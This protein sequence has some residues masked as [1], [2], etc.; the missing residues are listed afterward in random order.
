MAF[1]LFSISYKLARLSFELVFNQLLVT[2][3]APLDVHDGQKM[4]QI[5]KNIMS[6]FCV[7][8]MIFLSVKL[9][10]IGTAW[11]ENQFEGLVYLVALIGFSVAVL[12]GPHIV[13]RL[14][15]IDAGLKT[16]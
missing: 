10:I 4:K 14:F 11:L 16:D 6:I 12:D 8:I 1:V 5:L 2:I 3:I 7:I 15:G 9:Y 13:E